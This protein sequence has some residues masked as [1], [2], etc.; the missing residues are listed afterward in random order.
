MSDSFS[1]NVV[2][3]GELLAGY[4][5]ASVVDAFAKMFKLSGEKAVSMVGTR[6]VIKRGVELQLAKTYQKKLAAIGIEVNL[7][8]PEATSELSLEPLQQRVSSADGSE[9]HLLEPGQM[10]CPKCSF[11]QPKAE[12]CVNCGVYI[13]KVIGLAAA[14]AN[15]K[16]GD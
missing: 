1:Y 5:T 9:Q 15:I 10:L 4:E 8:L 7:E 2:L 14:G 3:S 12:E 11:L 13:H 6:V 16:S